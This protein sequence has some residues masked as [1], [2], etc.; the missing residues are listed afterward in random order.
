MEKVYFTKL[1]EIFM[2]VIGLMIE[3]R[4]LASSNMQMEIVTRVNSMMIKWMVLEQ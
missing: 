1:M 4:V 2:I 3:K